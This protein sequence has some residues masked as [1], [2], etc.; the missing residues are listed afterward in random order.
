MD[1]NYILKNSKTNTT[2]SEQATRYTIYNRLKNIQKFE[3]VE[4][5]KH[6]ITIKNIVKSGQLYM[7]SKLYEQDG[8]FDL[9][10]IREI[11]KQFGVKEHWTM[12]DYLNIENILKYYPHLKKSKELVTN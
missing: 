7:A 8:D 4:S 12:R 11:C 5:V 2:H 6:K 3:E 9:P 1:T 10:Q